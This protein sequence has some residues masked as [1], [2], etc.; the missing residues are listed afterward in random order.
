MSQTKHPVVI[1]NWKMN[2][3]TQNE[4][5][6]IAKATVAIAKKNTHATVVAC[7]PH[8][9]I[10]E[11]KKTTGQGPLLVGAQNCHVD[12]KGA[13]TGEHAAM[14]IKDAGGNYVIVGHSERR[15]MGEGNELIAKK[16]LA[17]TVAKLSPILCVGE[18]VR[19]TQGNFLTMIETQVVTALSALPK[20]RLKDVIIAYE[21]IWAIGT[22]ATATV[23]DVEEMQMFIKK[24]LT[25]QFD[26]TI[27]RHVRIVYGGS[28]NAD[29]AR[30]LFTGSGVDGFLVGGA[31]LK[32]VDFGKIVSATK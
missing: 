20:S 15:K 11:V 32:P 4:A 10:A 5:K 27:A 8:I 28:V 18:E 19:D 3:A 2:P 17:A 13:Y 29:N 12:V 22:G 7:V 30:E 26:R 16:M 31:S 6:T 9:Y 14:Q 25:K 23:A 1:A 21:P 24:V